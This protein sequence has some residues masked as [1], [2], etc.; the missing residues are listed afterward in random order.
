M[1]SYLSIAAKYQSMHKKKTRLTILSIILAVALVVGIFSILDSLVKFEKLQVLKT[2]GNYHILL[3]NPAQNEMGFIGSR[4]D[5]KSSG[6][7]KDLG[8]GET[9][10]GKCALC[11]I[12]ENFAPNLNVKLAKGSFPVAQNEILME[13]WYIDKNNMA[14]G[15]DIPVTLPDGTKVTYKISG[16]IN[17]WGATK[18]AAV[19]FVFLSKSS[20]EKIA[21]ISSQYHILFKDG[22]NIKSAEKQITTVLKIPENRVGYNEGLLALM[23]QSKNNKV[24]KIYGIGAAMFILVLITAVVM[25][26]NTFNISVVE[27]IR[28]FGLLRCIGASKTQIRRL[29]RRESLLL[30]LKAVPLGVIAG[31]I[32]SFVCSGVLKFYNSNLFGNI[33]VFNI[34]IIGILAGVLTGFL[35]VFM[36]SL[37]PA[38]TASKVSPVN[39]VTGMGQ[40]Y[41][42]K[43]KKQGILTRILSAEVAIGVNNAI[44]KKR[45]L[46]LMSSSIA[47]SIVLF[48]T[49]S[50]MVNPVFLGTNIT[51]AYTADISFTSD[52]GESSDILNKVAQISGVKNAYGRMDSIVNADFNQSRLTANYNN[53]TKKSWLLSYDAKQLKW[54]KDYL[55]DGTCNED[56]LNSKN[57]IIAVRKIHKSIDLVKTTDFQ[58]GDKVYISNN[59][60]TKEFTVIGI[61][62]Y[63]PYSPDE[64]IITTFITTEKLFKQV[65]V[66]TGY[67]TIDIQLK[68]KNQEDTI[69]NIKDIMGNAMTFHDKRQMNTEADNAFITVAVFIYGFICVIALISVLNII[70]TMNTSIASKTKYLGVM[71][72]VGMSGKQLSRMVLAQAVMYNLTGCLFGCIFGIM[73]Q[74][75]LIGLLAADW[76]FPL[77]QILAIFIVCTL[78]SVFSTVN[79]LKKIRSKGISETIA[80]L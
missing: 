2:E 60:K 16:V 38:K 63:A 48:L 30:C 1:N 28:Q 5:V 8:N 58:L 61:M 42:T 80:T 57:G 31:V 54:A 32:M 76:T 12:D 26:Y 33:S 14:I 35:S 68:S 69:S 45:T 40:I 64:Q 22:V 17:D 9:N 72:A 50:I 34:S 4:A 74:R 52:S 75:K 13:N 56:E 21:A 25:I 62:D 47:I 43:R 49:F 19:P 18:A 27:R 41:T 39:A 78:I 29:V 11:Y 24:L 71:R 77:W 51:K 67:K 37:L 10:N 6:L 7:I 44:N 46:V 65:S 79:P 23:M 20:S 59:N 66:D 70:N 15:D 53:K 73:L 3:R 36:A 55:V